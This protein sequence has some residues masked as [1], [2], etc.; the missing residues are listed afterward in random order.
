MSFFFLTAQAWTHTHAWYRGQLTL[1]YQTC[2]GGIH[3][4]GGSS[5][6]G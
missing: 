4:I 3:Y 5:D 2:E 6:A 1:K